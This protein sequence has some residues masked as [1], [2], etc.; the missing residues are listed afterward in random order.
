MTPSDAVL[1]M[2]EHKIVHFRDGDLEITLHPAAFEEPAQPADDQKLSEDLDDK[3]LGRS[4]ITRR[5]QFELLGFVDENDF[6]KAG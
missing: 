2:R 6:R 5:R 4:G 1:F 3:E